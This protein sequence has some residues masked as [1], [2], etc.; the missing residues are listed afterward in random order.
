M[1]A[2]PAPFADQLY[3]AAYN[4][5]AA[6]VARL[7]DDND[8]LP[9]RA[10]DAP[11]EAAAYE[12]RLGVTRLLLDRGADPNYCYAPTQE[13]IL[14]FAT[15]KTS[16]PTERTEIVKLLIAAGADV[17]RRTLVGEPTLCY[18]RDIRTRGETP[19]H[20]A[21]AYGDV[22]MIQALVDAGADKSAKDVHGESPLTWASWHLRDNAVLKLLLYGEFVGSI[23]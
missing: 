10:V 6:Q 22:G 9:P 8:T 16:R 17:N 5:D 19:L 15:S 23:R 7:L 3:D 12:G 13:T 18:M 2:N 20:R 21:A 1:P 14:H 4:G 11:L